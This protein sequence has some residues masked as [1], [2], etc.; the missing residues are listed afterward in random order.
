MRRVLKLLKWGLVPL[1][2]AGFYTSAQA[3][4]VSVTVTVQNVSPTSTFV[5]PLFSSLFHD[6]SGSHS[7]HDYFNVGDNFPLNT[8]D[9]LDGGCAT[10]DFQCLLLRSVV[11]GDVQGISAAVGIADDPNGTQAAVGTFLLPGESDSTTV[12]TDDGL[13]FFSYLAKLVPTN[14]SFIGSDEALAISTLFGLAVGDSLPF[15]SVHL[16]D[17]I[18]LGV[19]DDNISGAVIFHGDEG[20]G[21]LDEDRSISANTTD[22]SVFDGVST[23]TGTFDFL[24]L[25]GDPEI[26]RITLTLASAP[27]VAASA[28]GPI[29]ILGLSLIGMALYRRKRTE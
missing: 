6:G 5:I 23:D 21:G 22:F 25:S 28:P 27:L 9:A 16:S 8:S 1:L 13:T 4:P 29:G 18:N 11:R 2:A 20:P 17:I 15:I 10:S 24:A 7:F 19:E 3:A 14:D 26:L 12:V